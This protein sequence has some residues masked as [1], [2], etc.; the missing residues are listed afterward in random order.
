MTPTQKGTDMNTFWQINYW[1]PTGDLDFTETYLDDGDYD[2]F[3]EAIA[4]ADRI[5]AR[6]T[7][8][9]C[10]RGSM[11]DFDATAVICERLADLA[12]ER[13]HDRYLAAQFSPANR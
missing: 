5:G 3:V 6:F 9:I 2:N 12:C 13:Q 11:R 10:E 4:D 7:T 8:H 1:T